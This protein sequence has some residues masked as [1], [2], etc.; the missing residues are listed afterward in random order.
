MAR[1][2]LKDATKQRAARK[3]AQK[4]AGKGTK[5]TSK[6]P[7]PSESTPV[8]VPTTPT[9]T[10]SITPTSNGHKPTVV[11]NNNTAVVVPG[12]PALAP[13]SVAG[14][15]PQFNEGAYVI[16]DPLNPPETLPQVTETQ[17]NK[18]EAILKGTDRALKLTGLAMDVADTRFTVIGKRA[19]AFGSGI[20]AATAI[21]RV[22][23]DYLDYQSQVETTSQK[24]I[25]LENNQAK[26]INERSI[27]THTQASMDEKLKQAEADADMARQKTAEKQNQLAEFKKQ[28]GDYLPASK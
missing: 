12:L 22:K 27:S 1:T 23:G 8:S 10:T 6:T 16:N 3:V 25:A 11:T 13:D 19:K 4:V 7:A 26:T 2:S 24:S 14:M 5:T 21:E 20:K 9:T 17:F 18:A 15:L 28:L